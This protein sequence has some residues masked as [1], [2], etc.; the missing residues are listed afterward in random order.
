MIV[1]VTMNHLLQRYGGA[2]FGYVDE[3][4]LPDLL[5]SMFVSG[6]DAVLRALAESAES[7]FPDA[8]PAI[9]QLITDTAE[10]EHSELTPEEIHKL[11][12]ADMPARRRPPWWN[13]VRNG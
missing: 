8:L 2:A 3:G 12:V 4:F 6:C 5:R 7:Q 11:S 13:T 1:G 9:K 10:V